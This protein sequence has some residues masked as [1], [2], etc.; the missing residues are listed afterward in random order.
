M[1]RRDLFRLALAMLTACKMPSLQSKKGSRVKA[2]L[3]PGRGRKLLPIRSVPF[4][5]RVNKQ[6][7]FVSLFGPTIQ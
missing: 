2:Y 6:F 1:T 4:R 3:V 7:E 5:I